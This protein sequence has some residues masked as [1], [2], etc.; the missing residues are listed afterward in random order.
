MKLIAFGSQKKTD[1]TAQTFV[2]RERYIMEEK[3]ELKALGGEK[4]P[5]TRFIRCIVCERVSFCNWFCSHRLWWK[6]ADS[7]MIQLTVATRRHRKILTHTHNADRYKNNNF[8]H[9]E[10]LSLI[11]R[12]SFFYLQ[13][14]S[15]RWKCCLFAIVIIILCARVHF[16]Q[17]SSISRNSCVFFYIR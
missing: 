2:E 7:F 11:F 8:R 4:K 5:Y 15:L 10:L 17:S 14:T 6:R 16:C 3:S 13:S 12:R 9:W 1:D